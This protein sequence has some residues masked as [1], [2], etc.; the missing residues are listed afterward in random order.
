MKNLPLTLLKAYAIV[1]AFY[2]IVV[3]AL[4]IIKYAIL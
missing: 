3:A 2:A 1:I 4:T